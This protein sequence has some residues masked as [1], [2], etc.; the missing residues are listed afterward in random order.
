MIQVG[1]FDSYSGGGNGFDG[2]WGTNPYLPSG[3]IIHQ[4]LIAVVDKRGY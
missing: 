4:I 1:Y 3:N 2:C